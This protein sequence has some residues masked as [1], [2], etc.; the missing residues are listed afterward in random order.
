MIATALLR[1]WIRRL[2]LGGAVLALAGVALGVAAGTAS[3]AGSGSASGSGSVNF[4]P[5]K[6]ALLVRTDFPSGWTGQGSVSTSKS[7]SG[8]FPGDAQLA[9]CLGVAKSFLD[10]NT[11]SASSPTFQDKTGTV[12]VQDN[13]SVFPSAKVGARNF[14]TISNPKVPGCLNTVLMDPA[15]KAQ[16]L[17][18]TDGSVSVGAVT[19]T[20][21]PKSILVPH[22]SGFTIAF[23]ATEQESTAH[24]TI[25]LV[26]M[27]RGTLG[28]QIA[29]TSVSNAFPTSLARHL[30]S[31]AY[32]R[33]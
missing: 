21:A 11:P 25:T 5:A 10:T 23:D 2:A 19:V 4:A 20:A 30:V 29:L 15:A 12:F 26:S 8:K 28:S 33:T 31:T 22:A 13:V 32:G 7:G 3:A 1:S 9:S 6:K 18:T 17:G 27:V 14:S 24:T 16:F